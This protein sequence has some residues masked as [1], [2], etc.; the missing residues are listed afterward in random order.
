ME[1]FGSHTDFRDGQVILIDKPVRWTSFDIVKKVRHI[2]KKHYHY[3]K[4]KVGHAGTLDPLA[5]GLL[6]I[7]TGKATKDIDRMQLMEKEYIATIE[8]GKSTPSYDLE[9][10][11]D[12]TYPFEHITSDLVTQ[13]LKQ[14][15]GVISQV[16][17]LYSAKHLNGKRAYEHA[18]NGDFIEMQA[19][20]VEIHKIQLL[21]YQSPVAKILISCSKGTYIRS[22]AKDIGEACQSGAYLKALQRTSISQYKLAESLTIEAFE[23]KILSFASN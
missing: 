7:C 22:L 17:R 23:E 6:I 19:H 8:F 12:G 20:T 14:F 15:E 1:Q 18:R 4:L 21:E 16:P 3:S 10:A 13:V 9:T 11:F 5:S 2:L